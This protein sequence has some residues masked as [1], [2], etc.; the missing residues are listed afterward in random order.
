MGAGPPRSATRPEGGFCGILGGREISAAGVWTPNA[1]KICPA[2]RAQ[3]VQ[4]K[5]PLKENDSEGPGRAG[6]AAPE[7]I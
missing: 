1:L 3:E 6:Q 2:L 7:F 5:P 4:K